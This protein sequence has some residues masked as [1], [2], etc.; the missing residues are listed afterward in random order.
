MV[1]ADWTFA[2]DGTGTLDGVIKYSGANSYK[3]HMIDDGTSTL[4]HDTFLEPQAQVI[5]WA[6]SDND[7]PVDTFNYTRNYVTLSTYGSIGMD[8][9]MG[10]GV[11]EKFKISFWYD[12][13]SDMKFGRLEKWVLSAWEQQGDDTNFGTGSP[14]PGTIALR[15]T[16]GVSFP[17]TDWGTAWFDDVDIFA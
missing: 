1:F 17:G 6:R 11:W 10:Y 13:D 16:V 5:L 9:Y 8:D 14:L 12:I 2:G 3:S 15:N 4:T 7:R